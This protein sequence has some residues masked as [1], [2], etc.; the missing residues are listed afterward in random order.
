MVLS[1][2][3]IFQVFNFNSALVLNMNGHQGP[4]DI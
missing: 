4:A 2:Q 1:A 3:R